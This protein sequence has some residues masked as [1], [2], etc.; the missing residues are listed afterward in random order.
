MTQT[1][2]SAAGQDIG[3]NPKV[4]WSPA[5]GTAE[6]VGH[7]V[8][9]TAGALRRLVVPPFRVGSWLQMMEFV[10]VGSLMIVLLTGIFTGAVFSIQSAY[11]FSLFNAESLIGGTVALSLVL[12]LAPTLSAL[13]VAGRVG[14]AMCTELGTMRVTEQID[15][16]EVMAVDPVQFLVAPRLL[17]CTIM[18]PLLCMCFNAVG[19]LGA[20]VVG[21]TT[22]RLD[23]AEFFSRIYEWVEPPDIW[24]GLIKATV[25]G[26]IIGSIA[27]FN[28]YN[29][30]G[31]SRGVGIATTRTVVSASVTVLFADWVVTTIWNYW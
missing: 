29:A 9:F 4:L 18:Q 23:H 11:A 31:G 21:R 2:D 26:F 12:E 19:L 8:I 13:M 1:A 5:I 7:Y 16:M 6:G 28:G 25:F 30:K 22:L 20:Y 3:F 14:S 15:A 17:A 27:C 10:G 24:I